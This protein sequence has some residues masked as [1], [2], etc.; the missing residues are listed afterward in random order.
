MKILYLEDN[1]KS[2]I[3]FFSYRDEMSIDLN[4]IIFF[5]DFIY[6]YHLLLDKIFAKKKFNIPTLL[7]PTN[8]VLTISILNKSFSIH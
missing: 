4:Q 2:S 6:I 5:H 8:Y 7:H 3:F 1:K